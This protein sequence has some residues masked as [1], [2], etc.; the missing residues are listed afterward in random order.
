MTNISLDAFKTLGLALIFLLIGKQ[1]KKRITIFETFAIP[2]PVVGGTLFAIIALLLRLAGIVSFE[3]DDSFKN[4]FMTMFFCSVG[5][6]ASIKILKKG[7]I[8]VVKF[9]IVAAAL[10]VIQ[11][12]VAVVLAPIVHINPAIAFLTGSTPMTGGHGT[13]GAIAPLFENNFGI[14]KA[15]TVALTSAT[16]G[17]VAGSLVGGPLA[18]RLINKRRLIEKHLSSESS[19][20]VDVSI[21]KDERPLSEEKFLQ[22]FFVLAIATGLGTIITDLINSVSTNFQM[23]IY[24]GPMILGIILRNVF[25][26]TKNEIPN[27]ELQIIGNASLQIF[28]AIALMTLKLWELA[29]LAL[30]LVILLLAQTIVM[31]IYANFVTFKVMGGNY[32]AAVLA[33]GHCGFGMGATPNGVAN[34]ES[35]TEKY[36]ASPVAFFVLPIVGGFFIDFVNVAIINLFIPFVV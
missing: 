21:L 1:L 14:A 4:L 6:N 5:F 30:P 25:E 23:P 27:K 22:A 3:Y 9:L 20:N 28:L 19:V 32:D 7:G 36:V 13:S 33:A 31:L 17:L 34:M 11:N 18:T 10:C 16:Y 8:M 29:S 35:V 26:D 24:T 12:L 15:N 2:A